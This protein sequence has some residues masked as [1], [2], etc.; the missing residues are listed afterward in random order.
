MKRIFFF[1]LIT[2]YVGTA[3]AQS[4]S[5]AFDEAFSRDDIAA[6]REALELCGQ[7]RETATNL[8]KHLGIEKQIIFP[9]WRG[10]TDELLA[11][12]EVYVS[13]SL[14]EG[15]PLSILEAQAHQVPAVCYDVDGISEVI[16]N[17]RTGFLVKTND[18]SALA[19]KMTALLRNRSL[20]E[21]FKQNIARRD[22]GEFTVPV[23]IRRQ[24]QLYRSLV[25]QVR[26]GRKPFF[27][28][29]K[30]FFKRKKQT[31]GENK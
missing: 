23:M 21:R 14:R 5:D 13:T 12:S 17:N 30:K 2:I 4:Y 22:F 3:F 6:Q 8:A 19:E 28:R 9:G 26:S 18:I 10:D 29:H 25:P 20:H 24:E 1:L 15:I 7:L 11:I 27:R 31:A 16:A